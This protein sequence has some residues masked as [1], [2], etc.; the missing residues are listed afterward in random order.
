MII[1]SVM[2]VIRVG[3][4]KLD[5][6]LVSVILLLLCEVVLGRLNNISKVVMMLIEISFID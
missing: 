3:L 6:R 2:I 4:V 1:S 5:N